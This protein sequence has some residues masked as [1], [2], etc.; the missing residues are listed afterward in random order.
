MNGSAHPAIFESGKVVNWRL[1]PR[2]VTLQG[3]SRFSPVAFRQ[4]R[5]IPWTRVA[6]ARHETCYGAWRAGRWRWQRRAGQW[7][8]G[9]RGEGRPATRK[10]RFQSHS[11]PTAASSLRSRRRTRPLWDR[12]ASGGRRS[13]LRLGMEEAAGAGVLATIL[14]RLS[15]LTVRS[16]AFALSIGQAAD[17]RCRPAFFSLWEESQF[18][19]L[20]GWSRSVEPHRYI[21]L[22]N[23]RRQGRTL[24]PFAVEIDTHVLNLRRTQQ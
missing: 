1:D 13:G 15:R 17:R 19:V 5:S 8:T 21:A 24:T 22:R 16:G 23:V 4:A 6:I 3:T 12:A 18:P 14:A 20:L 10:G 2:I 9:R 7:S 11:R